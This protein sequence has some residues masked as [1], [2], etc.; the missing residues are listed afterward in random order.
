MGLVKLPSIKDYW[1]NRKLYSIPLAR[2]V[3]PRNRF[4]LILK[5][6]HF[7]DNQTADTD[8]R[9]YKIKDVLNMFIKNYQNVYTPGEKDV[10]MGH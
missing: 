10:S 1:R 4:E 7:A 6:V 5:F 3:M 8:D 9:L 2:T